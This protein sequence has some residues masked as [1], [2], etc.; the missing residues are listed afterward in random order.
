LGN[1]SSNGMM[2][3][4]TGTIAAT[5]GVL[6]LIGSAYYDAFNPAN[7]INTGTLRADGEVDLR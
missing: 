7:T 3:T 5:T 1:I 6:R 4:N 2:L